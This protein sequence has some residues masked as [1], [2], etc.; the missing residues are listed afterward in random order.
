M[1][2]IE[3]TVKESERVNVIN[4]LSAHSVTYDYRSYSYF[5][6]LIL[7]LYHSISLSLFHYQGQGAD[8]S[9]GIPLASPLIA[10]AS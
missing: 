8:A 2:Q 10:A 9:P 3:L 5:I 1:R 7:N 6:K 4:M